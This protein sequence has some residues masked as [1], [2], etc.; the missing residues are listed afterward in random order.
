MVIRIQVWKIEYMYPVFFGFLTETEGEIFMVESMTLDNI[1]L[2][3][4]Q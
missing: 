1:H 4:H 2:K 3:I